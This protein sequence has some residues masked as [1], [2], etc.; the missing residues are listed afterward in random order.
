MC[1]SIAILT[2]YGWAS[3]V[4]HPAANSAHLTRP[5]PMPRAPR[6]GPV[7][8]PRDRRGRA[9]RA[10]QRH[11]RA[12]AAGRGETA[13]ADPRVP[14][15]GQRA[16]IAGQARGA[17]HFL[18]PLGRGVLVGQPHVV[19]ERARE[20]EGLLRDVAHRAAQG[21]ERQVEH[22]AAPHPP[23]APRPP[24]EPPHPPPTGPP[25]PPPPPPP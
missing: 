20:E 22:L 4:T 15:R 6:G 9:R 14:A 10:R 17:G 5:S 16:Q 3:S 12:L 25:S 19:A 8:G 11:A 13:L 21:P 1:S 18:E 24:L 23:P 2:R 7:S